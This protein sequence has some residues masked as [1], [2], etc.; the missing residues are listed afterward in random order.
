MSDLATSF[1]DLE[2][3]R[4]AAG[5]LRITLDAPGLNSVNRA[6]HRQLADVWRAVDTDSETNVV[7]LRGAGKAFSAGG[8]FDML[9]SIVTDD[10]VRTE[11]RRE[12]RDLVFNVLE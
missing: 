11:I 4:P 9:E 3:D 8:S 2:F 6:M 12:A 7:L 10:S 5:V 1:P